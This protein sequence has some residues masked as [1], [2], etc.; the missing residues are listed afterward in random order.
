MVVN[1]KKYLEEIVEN[2]ILFKETGFT[3][4]EINFMNSIKTEF[5]IR[6][7]KLIE[8]LNPVNNYCVISVGALHVLTAVNKLQNLGYYSEIFSP[9]KSGFLSYAINS[10]L[11]FELLNGLEKTKNS[12]KKALI[13]AD[14]HTMIYSL[15]G[16]LK[17]PKELLNE[18]IS[19]VDIGLEHSFPGNELKFLFKKS[20]HCFH[21]YDELRDYAL[22]CLDKN[23]KLN[24]IGLECRSDGKEI[25]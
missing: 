8:N 14:R 5:Y 21:V 25:C 15:L 2:D 7:K 20:N 9:I 3:S 1:I 12:I 22:K 11:S 24:L 19:Q 18:G 16:I 23:I 6:D 13:I 4:K 17:E 10:S